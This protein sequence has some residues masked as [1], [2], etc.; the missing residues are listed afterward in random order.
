MIVENVMSRGVSRA[1]IVAAPPQ[2]S[3][4]RASDGGLLK[5]ELRA[6]WMALRQEPLS[7][8]FLCAYF[9]F[10]Y[11]RPQSILRWLDVLPWGRVT[12]LLTALAFL[13]EGARTRRFHLLDCLLLL[14]TGIWTLS[15]FSAVYPDWSVESAYVFI[16]W[17]MV[18]VLVTH[19]VTTERRFLIF[20]GFFL[21]WSL[22]LS[23]HGARLFILSGFHIP[24]WGV[25]GPPGWFQNS[26]E[27][28]IQMCVVVPMGILFVVGLREHLTRWKFWALLGLLPSTA[29]LTVIMSN[30]R[31]SQLALAAVILVLVAQSRHRLRGL[32]S[33]GLAV[34]VLW[35][36]V[37]EKQRDRLGEMGDDRTS[38]ARLTYW[39]D[40]IEIANRYPILG[41][42]YK[43]W[44]PYYQAHYNPQGELPH[45]IFVEAGAE[46]GYTGLF[47]F[48]LLIGGT[49]VANRRTR[50][51]AKSVPVWGPF[52]RSTAFGFDAAMVG[53]LVAGFFVTVLYYPYF[54]ILLAF[55]AALFETTRQAARRALAVETG[56]P[57]SVS[58][59]RPVLSPMGVPTRPSVSRADRA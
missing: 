53:F 12:L 46:L 57:D 22:K 6:C 42:G 14:F 49:F 59:I 30:S 35:A 41:I 4:S 34:A 56:S 37:P 8:W 27:L 3:F 50:R 7:F 32:L 33:A 44:I 38:Q 28:A 52:L 9:L 55:T 5:L 11:V 18:Y 31:G 17:L 1:A 16:N 29:A 43:N 26:G 19:I 40:G 58:T 10:E 2:G 23:Q 25:R 54:W 51:L 36:V 13:A 48:L 45:N 20:L 47:A 15:I 39:E 21:L 24:S